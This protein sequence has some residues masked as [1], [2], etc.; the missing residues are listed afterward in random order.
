MGCLCLTGEV[1]LAIAGTYM[2]T[3]RPYGEASSLSHYSSWV[4]LDTQ[5]TFYQGLELDHGKRG[6][7]TLYNQP[8]WRILERRGETEMRW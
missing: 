2:A 3:G 8:P 5:L 4:S 6:A 7:G 1:A